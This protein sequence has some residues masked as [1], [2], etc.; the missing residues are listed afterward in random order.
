[1]NKADKIFLTAFI[2]IIGLFIA[3]FVQFE[4]VIQN[5]WTK[6]EQK[7]MEAL[8]QEHKA[9]YIC[10]DI[11]LNWYTTTKQQKAQIEPFLFYWIKLSYK[12]IKANTDEF[13]KI[14]KYLQYNIYNRHLNI[15]VKIILKYLKKVLTN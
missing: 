3:L 13:K 7:Q 12:H 9:E 1:M 14:F 5:R 15:N 2:I 11:E 10:S 8:K 4:I 6:Y